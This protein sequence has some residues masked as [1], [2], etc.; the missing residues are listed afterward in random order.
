[1]K[2][3]RHLLT[4]VALVLALAVLGTGVAS[5]GSTVYGKVTSITPSN[6]EYHDGGMSVLFTGYCLESM[7]D[8]DGTVKDR[9][10]RIRSGHMVQ[11]MLDYSP[12][13][14]D[15]RWAHRGV[16]MRNAYSTLLAAL[17]SGRPVEIQTLDCSDHSYI[18]LAGAEG[19]RISLH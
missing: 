10:I 9:W 2:T 1:M 14:S 18:D 15:V 7:C 12:P 3:M 4:G 6:E 8:N 13:T 17:L 5:A 19:V 11:L 16:N